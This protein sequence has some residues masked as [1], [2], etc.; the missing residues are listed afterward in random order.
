MWKEIRISKGAVRSLDNEEVAACIAAYLIYF[1]KKH[2]W[3]FKEYKDGF[4]KYFV[5]SS[6]SGKSFTDA[7]EEDKK[8]FRVNCCAAYRS[9]E[10]RDQLLA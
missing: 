3:L 8:S 10:R 1:E 7:E 9:Q 2:S 4:S 5:R 6:L